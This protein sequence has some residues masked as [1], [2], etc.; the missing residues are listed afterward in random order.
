[1]KRIKK[2]HVYK[3]R[4]NCVV[5]AYRH[6]YTVYV[7]GNCLSWREMLLHKSRRGMRAYMRKWMGIAPQAWKYGY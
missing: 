1:M 6:L 2:K 4:L 3:R 5:Q 7:V